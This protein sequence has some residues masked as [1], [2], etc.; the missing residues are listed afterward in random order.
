MSSGPMVLALDLLVKSGALYME[1]ELVCLF[2]ANVLTLIPESYCED[3]DLLFA[4]F[5]LCFVSSGPVVLALD[6]LLKSGAFYTEGELVRLFTAV[7]RLTFCGLC[8]ACVMVMFNRRHLLVLQQMN[9]GVTVRLDSKLHLS[10]STLLGRGKTDGEHKYLQQMSVG[11]TLRLDSKLHLGSSKLLGKVKSPTASNGFH[12][13]LLDTVEGR[14]HS[15]ISGGGSN[16]SHAIL[17]DIMEEGG[18]SSISGGDTMEGGGH[19]SLSDGGDLHRSSL[20]S[21][22]DDNDK[23]KRDMRP[24]LLAW[25]ISPAMFA[26]FLSVGTSMIVFPFFTFMHSTG[27]LH[28]RLPQV[29][30]YVRLIGDILGRVVP[31]RL[32]ATTIRSL[33]FWS[34]VKLAMVPLIFLSIF[35]PELTF[36]DLEVTFGYSG[37]ILYVGVF[38]MLSG[39]VNTCAYLM[40]PKLVSPSQKPRASGMM[41][42]AFQSSC[43]I[44][45]IVAAVIQRATLGEHEAIQ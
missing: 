3:K 20:G 26:M 45:L 36:G 19:S 11:V 32:Q 8:A 25:R 13:V 21:R 22:P 44:A 1:N 43:F 31:T 33:M 42:V 2:T 35:S 16:G 41:T 9:G 14:G 30:F 34:F 15:S 17:L 38:W 7:A 4:L 24:F 12:A 6:L 28:E 27:L 29:L 23:M 18:H 39:Y 37:A 5:R 10:S 40:A